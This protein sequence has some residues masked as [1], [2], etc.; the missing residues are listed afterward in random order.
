M[1]RTD[2]HERR[3][4]GQ[5]SVTTWSNIGKLRQIGRIAWLS[6][7]TRTTQSETRGCGMR[8]VFL[9]LWPGWRQSCWTWTRFRSVKEPVSHILPRSTVQEL[10]IARG[11]SRPGFQGC[12]EEPNEFERKIRGCSPHAW[13][14][15]RGAMQHGP[16]QH[17]LGPLAGTHSV[18]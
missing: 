12:P 6:I 2:N 11:E 10:C 8:S 9:S 18:F 14:L 17:P 7:G 16:G 1:I 3:C 4:M 15:T 13:P 5:C